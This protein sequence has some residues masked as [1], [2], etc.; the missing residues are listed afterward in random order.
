MTQHI[1]PSSYYTMRDDIPAKDSTERQRYFLN[2]A[3]KLA[4]KSGMGHK[5]G[6]VIVYEDEIIATG[7]NHHFTHMSHKYSLHAEM[8]AIHKTKKKYKH[9]LP[10]CELY[11]VRI[12]GKNLNNCLKY[13]KPCEDC[14]CEIKKCGI[15]KVYYSTNYEYERLF[16]EK[17]L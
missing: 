8:H 15:P 2:C 10:E 3:A 17:Y 4:M 7:Y 5:H 12:A 11:V 14:S 1:P 9:L 6:C 16:A 13:S